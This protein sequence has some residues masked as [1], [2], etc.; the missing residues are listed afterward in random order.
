MAK[1]INKTKGF[2]SISRDCVYDNDLSDRARF[3]Y[4]YMACKPEDWEFYQDKVAEELNYKKDTL[5]KYLDELIVRGWVTEK[6]QHNDGKFGCLEY[7][8]EIERKSGNLPIRKKPDTEKNRYGKNPN[9][10][11]I[12]NISSDIKSSDNNR[13]IE[14]KSISNDIPKNGH[15]RKPTVQEVQAYINEKGYDFDAEYF[16]DYYEMRGWMIK[17]NHMKD[18]KAACRLWN[19]NRK[20]YGKEKEEKEN[21]DTSTSDWDAQIRWLEKNTPNIAGRMTKEMLR[22]FKE[23]CMCDSYLLAETLREF[24]KIYDGGD[25][26]KEFEELCKKR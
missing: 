10:R 22:R 11:N 24:D 21:P 26:M 25:M 14:E 5:R 18:W 7:V 1:V 9:Q 16:I 23:L 12:D 6:E 4:V 19:H 15:F 13:D 2:G 8:I 20:S 3:L 17:N